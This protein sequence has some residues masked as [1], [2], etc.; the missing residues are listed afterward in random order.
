MVEFVVSSKLGNDA[1]VV[2][3]LAVAE[4]AKADWELEE[5]GEAG[6]KRGTGGGASLHFGIGFSS[7]VRS[8]WW[9]ARSR[10]GNSPR[11]SCEPRTAAGVA[12][13]FLLNEPCV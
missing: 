13:S 5:D 7:L 10:W 8:R 9:M 1:G 2:G 11:D 4:K 3:A 6:G 12:D